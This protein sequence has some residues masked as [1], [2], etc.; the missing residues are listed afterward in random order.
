LGMMWHTQTSWHML[1]DDI[2]INTSM[3]L[4]ISC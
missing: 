3:L 1:Y 2:I 4:K